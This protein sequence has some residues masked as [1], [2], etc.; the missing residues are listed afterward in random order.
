MKLHELPIPPS[1][2]LSGE[3]AEVLRVWINADRSMDV[4]LIPAFPDPSAWGILLVDIAR[5]VA[6]AYAKEGLA[7]EED[8]LAGIRELFHAE[9]D[10]PTDPGRTTPM[11]N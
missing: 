8:T 6:R 4:S 2:A 10:S 1:S 5:H 3:A 11:R 7:K 9:W